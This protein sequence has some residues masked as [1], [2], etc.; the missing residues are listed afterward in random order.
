M[1]KSFED[2]FDRKD[3]TFY[4][5]DESPDALKLMK[6]IFKMM[7]ARGW[8]V[9]TDQEVLERYSCLAKDHFEGQKEEL[10]FKAEKYRMGFKIEFFQDVNT[11]N[12]NGGRYDFEKF[13]LMPFLI[14]CRFLVEIKHIKS[15]CLAAGYEDH[16]SGPKKQKA[17]D[18]IMGKIKS[19]WH[20]K[21][22]KELPSYEFPDYNAKDKDGKQLRNGQ[23]K[24]FRDH[25]GRLQKGVIYHNINNMW[26]TIL[27][28]YQYR[29]IAA[30]EFFDLDTEEN[31]VRK[32]VKPSG[33]H[34]PKSRIIPTLPTLQKWKDEAKK[35]GKEERMK[36]ANE[37]LGY[38]YSIGWTSRK[39]EFYLKPSGRL[40]LQE[41]E[42]RAWGMHKVFEEPEK[43]ALYT[44]S[45][46]MSSTEASWV[47][48][49]REY[50][51]NGKAAINP[52]F[53]RDGSGGYKWPEV[54]ERLWKIGAL[55]S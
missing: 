13:S 14:R 46:P 21:E 53:C 38:L 52:W 23:L 30:F 2:S 34:N 9:Q 43:L 37:V 17:Y 20:Y 50:T 29:N 19:C 41:L 36:K 31:R 49:L 33:M 7:T 5:R 15:Y 45:L 42:S 40:G 16:S 47:K 48:G 27:N 54:R 3:T 44:R 8:T 11:V 12:Q 35:A 26:W 28:E 32:Y 25:K 24:Y 18:K 4:V 22:G 6:G 51:V 55:A 10:K 39:F 1:T